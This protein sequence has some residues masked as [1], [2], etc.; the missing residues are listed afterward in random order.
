MVNLQ[1]EFDDRTVVGSTGIC[2]FWPKLGQDMR[3][4][5]LETILEFAEEALRSDRHSLFVHCLAGRTRSAAITY[6]VLRLLGD[7]DC[8]ARARIEKAEPDAVL[9]DDVLPKLSIEVDRYRLFARGRTN[10]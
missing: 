6:A 5:S 8:T 10:Y 7:S 1:D 9:E 4:A 3:Q 2:V